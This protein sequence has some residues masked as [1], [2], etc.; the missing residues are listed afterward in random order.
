MILGLK[1]LNSSYNHGEHKILCFFPVSTDPASTPESG[2][3]SNVPVFHIVIL[4]VLVIG[5]AS[6][7]GL[8][9]QWVE[10]SGRLFMI[11]YN[12]IQ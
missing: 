8:Q 4:I 10:W 6:T 3:S 12:T 11:H 7:I 9:I 5:F 2:F 1:Y